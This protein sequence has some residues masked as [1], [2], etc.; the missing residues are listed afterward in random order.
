MS[1]HLLKCPTLETIVGVTIR[2]EQSLLVAH[3]APSRIG[4]NP[5]V[6]FI[7]YSN[8][9]PPESPYKIYLNYF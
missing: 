5:T 8:T 2:V 1:I 6:G 4:S 7:W 9:G 3:M